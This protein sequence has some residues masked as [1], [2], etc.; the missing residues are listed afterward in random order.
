MPRAQEAAVCPPG[1]AA[2][3]LLLETL[4]RRARRGADLLRKDRKAHLAERLG[5]QRRTDRLR[6]HAASEMERV[7]LEPGGHEVERQQVSRQVEEIA[8]VVSVAEP[9][10]D[11]FD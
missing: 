7:L 2:E 3:D 11:V 5:E 6:R 10:H 8:A 9:R 1:G 4:R